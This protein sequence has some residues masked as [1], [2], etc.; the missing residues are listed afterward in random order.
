MH[1]HLLNKNLPHPA[2]MAGTQWRRQAFKGDGMPVA[3]LP[4]DV[5][6]TDH[7]GQLCCR[8]PARWPNEDIEGHDI[9]SAIQQAHEETVALWLAGSWRCNLGSNGASAPHA[10]RPVSLLSGKIIR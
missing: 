6:H 5:F 10:E 8:E 3:E 9:L 1:E 4:G 2:N 7:R